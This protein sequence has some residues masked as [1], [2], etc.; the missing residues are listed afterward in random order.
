M[1]NVTVNLKNVDWQLLQKQKEILAGILVEDKL[2]YR[3]DKLLS[4]QAMALSG[5]LSLIDE[6][7][8]Q[9]ENTLGSATVFNDID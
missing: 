4:S 9:A 7:Q 3:Q 1:T 2:L 5:I 8:D 6:V